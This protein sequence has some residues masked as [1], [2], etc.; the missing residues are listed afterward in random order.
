MK[1]VLRDDKPI[2]YRPYRLSYYERERV[3]NMVDELKNANIVED[4]NSE[5]ASPILLVTK[6]TGDVRMC[7]DYRA[8][9][10]I[11]VPDKYPLPR[12]DDQIDRLHGNTYFTSLDLFSG[13]YQVPIN[14]PDTRAK[15]SFVTPDGKYTF[16]R[17]PFGPTNCPAIFSRIL[18]YTAYIIPR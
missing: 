4:S 12:I 9:N 6:K 3:R 7:V 10:K 18:Y 11:T 15:L 14:D 17:M 16:K 2:V 1:L 5:Y 13:Y 8:I